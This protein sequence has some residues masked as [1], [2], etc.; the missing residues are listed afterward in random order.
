MST[1]PKQSRKKQRD[2]AQE[3]A[4]LLYDIFKDD[5]TNANVSHANGKKLSQQRK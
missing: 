3:L 4:L 2:D 5:E 1:T